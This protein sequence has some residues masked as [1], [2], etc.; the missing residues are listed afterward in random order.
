MSPRR[1]G[2]TGL[3]HHTFYNISQK[4]KDAVCIYLDIYSTQTLDDFVK[5]FAENILGKGDGNKSAHSCLH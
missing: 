4:E 5:I 3:I 2:K 1:F